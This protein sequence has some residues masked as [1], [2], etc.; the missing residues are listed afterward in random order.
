M[1]S[2][3]WQKFRRRYRCALDGSAAGDSGYCGGFWA[4]GGCFDGEG[5]SGYG[6]QRVIALAIGFAARCDGRVAYHAR[7]AA[8][9]GVVRGEILGTIGITVYLGGGQSMIYGAEALSAFD[10]VVG[11]GE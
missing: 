6:E 1:S 11:A 7:A 4:I 5:S 2:S 9:R 10:G 8:R 3:D